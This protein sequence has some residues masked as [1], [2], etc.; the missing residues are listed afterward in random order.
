[1]EHTIMSNEETPHETDTD[2]TAGIDRRNFIKTGIAGAAGIAAVGAGMNT[3]VA[4][5]VAPGPPKR[6]LLNRRSA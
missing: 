4:Q 2:Q 6:S 1:M 5:P 3:A